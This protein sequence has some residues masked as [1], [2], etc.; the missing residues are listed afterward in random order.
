MEFENTFRAATK[1]Y[2]DY[3]REIPSP[4]LR[5]VFFLMKIRFAAIF[6]IF[7]IS[8][9]TARTEKRTDGRGMRISLP[10]NFCSL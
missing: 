10:S 4:Y 6:Q 2:A 1:E 3:D 5:G 9:L 8:R 7:T